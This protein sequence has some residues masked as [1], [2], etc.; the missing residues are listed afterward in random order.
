MADTAPR[1]SR[2]GGLDYVLGMTQPADAPDGAVDPL[3]GLQD[4]QAS[5]A[6][7]VAVMIG[8]LLTVV[9]YANSV[10]GEFVWDDTRQIVANHLIQHNQFFVKAM[11]SDVWAFKAET[12]GAASNY[13][14]PAAVLWM[15]VNHRLFGLSAPGWHV[16]NIGLHVVAVVLAYR[17]VRRLTASGAIAAAACWLFAVHPAHVESVAWVSGSH[18]ILMA[19]GMLGAMSVYLAVRER[20]S[21][22]S[23]IR[24]AVVFA[25]AMF[26]KETSVVFPVVI[27][28]IEWVLAGR[29]GRAMA[30][31]LRRSV[32]AAV[33]FVAVALAYVA[34]RLFVARIGYESSPGMMSLKGLLLFVTEAYVFF[35]R[36]SL[37]PIFLS[38][39]HSLN[40]A[41]DGWNA[42]AWLS[43]PIFAVLA[44]ALW[45]EFRRD[46]ISAVG[47]LLF[48]CLLALPVINGRAVPPEDRVHDRYL[49]LPLLG[50]LLIVLSRANTVLTRGGTRP[51]GERTLVIGAGAVAVVFAG[52]TINYNRAWQNSLSLWEAGVR[53]DPNGSDVHL[54]AADLHRK[55]GRFAEAKRLI[56]RALT[57]APEN[58]EAN[59]VQGMIAANEKRYADAEAVLTRVL[60]VHPRRQNAVDYLGQIYMEQG[61][62]DRAIAVFEKARTDMPLMRVKYATSIAV[63][64]NQAGMSGRAASELEAV[65]EDIARSPDR[66]L[67]PFLVML[68]EMQERQFR[69]AE[70]ARAYQRFLDATSGDDST[71]LKKYVAAAQAGLERTSG[72]H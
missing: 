30:M 51:S 55:A 10:S 18:D 14:R 2:S 31:R 36:Q 15:V 21:A 9:A 47:V 40:P 54:R 12:A 60:S 70:A 3:I 27:A 35:A 24:A 34:L 39:M 11:L 23:A 63:V 57:I 16:L 42:W 62:F 22:S 17:V 58:A 28:G 45:R 37:L 26:S 64:A 4:R 32:V 29:E 67:L 59:I 50:V 61:L 65:A 72:R 71:E 20:P 66:S 6:A 7:S 49:Y 53:G 56:E 69:P 43:P 38:P 19:I 13:W 25:L 1:V 52:L 44:V 48:V 5:P 68:G 46:A 41:P 8:V 33:P